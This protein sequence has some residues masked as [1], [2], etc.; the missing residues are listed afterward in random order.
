MF[1]LNQAV[2][3][4]QSGVIGLVYGFTEEGGVCISTLDRTASVAL[5]HP[6]TLIANGWQAASV[7]DV[8]NSNRL[9]LGTWAARVYAL[10]EESEGYSLSDLFASEAGEAACLEWAYRQGFTPVQAAE[11]IL[12]MSEDEP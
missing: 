11:K 7:Q 9:D 2:V 6:E 5:A 12:A 10:F 3:H 1:A 8:N 4:A